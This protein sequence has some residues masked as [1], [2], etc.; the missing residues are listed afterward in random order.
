M[1]ALNTQ[2]TPKKRITIKNSTKKPLPVA[3]NK[4]KKIAQ[5]ILK[6]LTDGEKW[7]IDI[8]FLSDKKIQTLN[9]KYLKHNYPTDVLAFNYGDCVADLAISLD[10]A[11]KN[12][13]IYNTSLKYE[14]LLYIIHGILHLK[15]YNDNNPRS[16]KTMFEKQKELFD[17]FYG[18]C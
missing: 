2:K 3:T 12:A 9:K 11:T 18:D 4:V 5:R 10:M 14:T 16:K 17:K 6:E 15:G 7:S 8:V 1:V 13:K